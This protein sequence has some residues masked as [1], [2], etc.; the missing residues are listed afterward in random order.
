MK[1]I[2]Q[3]K[4]KLSLKYIKSDNTKIFDLGLSL[5]KQCQR[6]SL[7]LKLGSQL[8]NM[9]VL[10]FVIQILQVL[11]LN[12]DIFVYITEQ[13]YETSFIEN[14]ITKQRLEYCLSTCF[15]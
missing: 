15:S 12:R 10:L 3:R 2:F 11:S 4:D 13:K 14:K 1:K 7:F 6:N 5:Y 8:S 9:H